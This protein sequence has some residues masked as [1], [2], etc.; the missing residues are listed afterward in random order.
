MEDNDRVEGKSLGINVWSRPSLEVLKQ[1][2]QQLAGKQTY[3]EK[4]HC[5]KQV[6][7]EGETHPY[8]TS[9]KKFFSLC[10]SLIGQPHIASQL[11]NKSVLSY[12]EALE[13][14]F[15]ELGGL[16]GYQYS[17]RQLI[18]EGDKGVE[19]DVAL[20]LPKGE[21]MEQED[22]RVRTLVLKA[23]EAQASFCELFP[24]GGAA[25]RLN[26]QAG[27]CL[28]GAS[29]VFFGKTL[30]LRLIEDVQS[31]EYLHFKLFNK[32]MVTPLFFMVSEHRAHAQQIQDQF[33]KAHHFARPPETITLG[34]QP[35]VPLFDEEGVWQLTEEAAIATR[36][37]GH[38]MLWRVATKK[39]WFTKQAQAGKQKLLVRQINNPVAN[40]DFTLLAF[41][42]LG[43]EK[44]AKFGIAGCA[45]DP[46]AKEGVCVV[47][48]GEQGCYLTNIEYCEKAVKALSYGSFALANTNILFADLK[49]LSEA[50]K[51]NP[52]P[53]KILN[54]RTDASGD[55]K[56][57]R[58]ETMMQNIS[59][60]FTFSLEEASPIF[61]SCTPR[62]KTISCTKKLPQKGEPWALE[63]PSRAL[64]DMMQTS[65]A[66]L[67]QHCLSQLPSISGDLNFL[68][69][70]HPALGP[71]YSVIGQKIRKLTLAKHSEVKLEIADLMLEEVEVAGSLHIEATQVMGD[72]D[73]QGH[74]TYSHKTGQCA[75]KKVKIVNQ[76]LDFSD[77]AMLWEGKRDLVEALEIILEGHS[78][79]VAESVTFKGGRRFIVPDGA[80]MEAYEDEKGQVQVRLRSISD[81][82]FYTYEVGSKGAIRLTRGTS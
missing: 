29:F 57:A 6:P 10:L 49:A 24:I 63:T 27:A 21:L 46:L 81:E 32:Q 44:K 69:T 71:L 7:F 52:L 82:P 73:G 22:E 76:G 45:R 75:L 70:Y 26:H 31:R 64:R 51:A 68:F 3:E 16:V 58:L 74:L 39:E 56:V 4:L 72:K 47:K 20:T 1:L 33:E 53:G 59:E 19:E 43:L 15:S 30:L 5:L 78:Q 36:P 13:E 28:A 14:N 50:C 80:L 35:L 54:F 8:L 23:I 17:V 66:L 61:L 37:G 67:E 48:Q 62:L 42:G 9:Q 2:S 12:L 40:T 55:K 41:Q 60:Q 77:Q 25:D 79:F 38:G 65:R 34:L 18:E 11:E